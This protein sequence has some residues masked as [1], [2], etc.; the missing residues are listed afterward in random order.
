[1]DIHKTVVRA[2]SGLLTV[3]GLL[4][5]TTATLAAPKATSAP[6]LPE[7]TPP[8]QLGEVSRADPEVIERLREEFRRE[9]GPG[10]TIETRRETGY[11]EVFRSADMA[12]TNPYPGATATEAAA[13]FIE[14]WRPLFGLNA[15]SV[16]EPT[17]R[18]QSLGP[19]GE[20]IVF[21][22]LYRG[23]PVNRSE[24]RVTI[25]PGAGVMHVTVATWPLIDI[26][27]RAGLT[28]EQ[29][30]AR[31]IETT[32]AMNPASTSNVVAAP[33]LVIDPRGAGRLCY[34][35]VAWVGAHPRGY[36]FL[37]DANTGTVVA[38]SPS[39]QSRSD[40]HRQRGQFVD[41]PR[42]DQGQ[43]QIG[44]P[45]VE[46]AC[47]RSWS[48]IGPPGETT[49]T[50]IGGH[51]DSYYVQ[52]QLGVSSINSL[53]S[54]TQISALYGA[55]LTLLPCTTYTIECTYDL[56]TWD[57]YNAA[58]GW[59]DVVAINLNSVGMIWTLP[60]NAMLGD[61]NC[62]LQ[63]SATPLPGETRR[64][65]GDDYNDGQLCHTSGSFT[66]TYTEPDPSKRVYLS[67]VLDTATSPFA[68]TTFPS[69][70]TITLKIKAPTAVFDPNPRV[71]LND[72]NL[73]YGNNADS[74][75]PANAY[76]HVSLTNLQV[77][78]TGISY[79]LTGAWAH[80]ADI[81][82]I[83]GLPHN[84]FIPLSHEAAF[85]RLRSCADFEGA[86]CYYHITKNQEYI[87]SILPFFP[88]N[89]RSTA[90]DPHALNGDDDAFYDPFTAPYALGAGALY[91][92]GNGGL[93]GC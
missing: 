11:A 27:V 78:A 28:P 21:R 93:A 54:A 39:G 60:N 24:I 46:D 47:E 57:A 44:Q 5:I 45:S 80:I 68:D 12:P 43:G 59:W 30:S 2:L 50:A 19:A 88:I 77:P 9:H 66:M 53:E 61:A 76:A 10:W 4:T 71:A 34:F 32:Q 18:N 26:D 51:P 22:Q 62:L 17:G 35:I 64:F 41:G 48:R 6:N 8:A 3:A 92:G 15:D 63:S 16:V 14:R 55:G 58:R 29:A 52:I 70:G 83:P 91:F 85:P 84:P 86:M 87:Q 79:T 33:E 13:A 56:S 89:A 1:M 74:A 25:G 49:I 23:V 67:L 40:G 7:P 37:V 42:Q 73:P 90:I 82:N 65:G 31:L 20:Q 72:P 36:Q 75:I 81:T 69:W 38:Y